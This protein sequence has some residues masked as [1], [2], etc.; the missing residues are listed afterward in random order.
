MLARMILPLVLGMLVLPV[1]PQDEPPLNTEATSEVSDNI[2]EVMKKAE[3]G[4]A[5][6]QYRLGRM[7]DAGQGVPQDFR[8]VV[9]W[10]RAA[11][12]QGHE[13]AQFSLG[14]MYFMG[15]AIPQ[16]YK[17][18]FRWYLAAAEQGNSSA[19]KSLGAMYRAGRGVPQDPIQAH[20]WY[21]LAASS[22]GDQGRKMA[23]KSRDSTAKKMT[24]EQ[25]AE[26]QRLAREWKPKV[27][28]AR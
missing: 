4:D 15:E 23:V 1:F 9:R 25:I 7:Y 8:E 12:E 16:D 26:A 17:E 22:G 2:A 19:Q 27:Q 21:N 11:A 28:E 14:F 3:E 13:S 6:A 18:A 24:A 20:M 10:F 5:S